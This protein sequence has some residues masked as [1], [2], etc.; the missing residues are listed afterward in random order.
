MDSALFES[1]TFNNVGGDQ[2]NINNYRIVL[3]PEWGFWG[4]MAI[5]AWLWFGVIGR[6]FLVLSFLR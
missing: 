6:C 5:L 4:F 3:P 2:Y 1:C